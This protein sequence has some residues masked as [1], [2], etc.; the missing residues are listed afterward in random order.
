MGSYELTLF[1]FFVLWLHCSDWHLQ[2]CTICVTFLL[3]LFTLYF[4]AYY[5]ECQQ[6]YKNKSKLLSSILVYIIILYLINTNKAIM[7][8]LN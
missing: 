8:T 1:I 6:N 5:N 3:F 4:R 2:R 7:I